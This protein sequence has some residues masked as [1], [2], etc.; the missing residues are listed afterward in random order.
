MTASPAAVRPALTSWEQAHKNGDLSICRTLRFVP[1]LVPKIVSKPVSKRPPR[2]DFNEYLPYL[3]NRVGLAL[4]VDFVQS[5]LV[6][7][8]LSIAM[9][10]VLAVLSDDGGAP[11]QHAV[12]QQPRKLG[13]DA[14]HRHLLG[15]VPVRH[16]VGH[17]ENAEHRQAGIEIG[18]ELAAP[19]PLLEHLLE[20]PLEA[21]RPFADPPPA[22]G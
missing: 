8:R 10:R 21:A 11:F 13:A 16:R 19:D 17:A 14:L 18:A 9:W 1:K 15:A 2:F 12:D 4:V 20:H 22:L 3:I 6:G 7:P 5:A